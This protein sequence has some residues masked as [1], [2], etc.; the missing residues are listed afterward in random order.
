[1]SAKKKNMSKQL[2][3]AS[4]LARCQCLLLYSHSCVLA[5]L[6]DVL[7]N[8]WMENA[9]SWGQI[10]LTF[11]VKMQHLWNIS[12]GLQFMHASSY[13][14]L[15]AV[16]EQLG[17]SLKTSLDRYNLMACEHALSQTWSMMLIRDLYMHTERIFGFPHTQI[18][19]NY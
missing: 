4:T 19:G 6:P 8:N 10:F 2:L 16:T 11:L 9:G 7:A 5:D 1:M 15:N 18:G 13:I 14:D 17:Y 12:L 3:A